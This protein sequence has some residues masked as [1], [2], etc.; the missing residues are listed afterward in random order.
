MTAMSERIF[1][2]RT[3][4]TNP[5]KLAAL[6]RRFRE[7]TLG[8]FERHGM[9]VVGFFTPTEGPDAERT[10]IYLLA[11]PDRATADQ[12][13]QNF[14]T[15]PDWIKAKDESEVDGPLMERIESQFLDPTDYSP[16]R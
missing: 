4:V 13:W 10:L 12:A 8:L 6:H 16:V 9:E 14:R 15:D 2:L 5:G 3:Y 1:E 11:F 7:H